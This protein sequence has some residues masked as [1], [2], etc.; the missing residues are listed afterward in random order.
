MYIKW[1]KCH[2]DKLKTIAN[3]L[4]IFNK[5]LDL[6]L[7]SNCIIINHTLS[8]KK[9]KAKSSRKNEP[10]AVLKQLAGVVT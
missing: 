1:L 5:G 4:I 3:P 8:N 2:D 6:D 10:D 7:A 9:T